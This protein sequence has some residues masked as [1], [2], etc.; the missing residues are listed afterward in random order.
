MSHG[1]ARS[2]LEEELFDGAW[3]LSWDPVYGGLV[4]GFGP[5]RTDFL[6][7]K[8]G[9]RPGEWDSM[10]VMWRWNGGRFSG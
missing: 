4:Y 6:G 8:G 10:G 3:D 1:L 5:D 7:N 2:A 9:P